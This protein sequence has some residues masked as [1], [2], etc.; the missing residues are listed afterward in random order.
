MATDL[1]F[2]F[3]PDT[4]GQLATCSGLAAWQRIY[5]MGGVT[6]NDCRGN[7]G[8]IL[9]IFR[10][11]DFYV[12]PEARIAQMTVLPTTPFSTVVVESL[13]PTDTSTSGFVS[14]G[15][16]N[17]YASLIEAPVQ[18]PPTSLTIGT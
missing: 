11:T 17:V 12:L 2:A 3:P 1:A 8:A 14:T 13:S 18:I 16:L 4:Y 9:A 5:V 6:D 7:V 10:S 15:L